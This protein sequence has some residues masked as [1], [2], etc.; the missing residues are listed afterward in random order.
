MIIFFTFLLRIKSGGIEK[1]HQ[2]CKEINREFK[3]KN[4]TK[5]FEK[6][7]VI[8]FGQRWKQ[9]FNVTGANVLWEEA[10]LTDCP[11]VQAYFPMS[12]VSRKLHY[13][14][15]TYSDYNINC[16]QVFLCTRGLEVPKN[17]KAKEVLS[18]ST[19][20]NY[21]NR[22]FYQVYFNISICQL[23]SITEPITITIYNEIEIP[24]TLHNVKLFGLI[25]QTFFFVICGVIA[26]IAVVA[27]TL[28]GTTRSTEIKAF[29]RQ[30]TYEHKGNRRVMLGKRSS[31]EPRT[32]LLDLHQHSTTLDS[33]E[34]HPDEG[35][36]DEGTSSMIFESLQY[37]RNPLLM[38]EM[39]RKRLIE[40]PKTRDKDDTALLTFKKRRISPPHHSV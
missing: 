37:R 11:V 3:N 21:A 5:R 38:T 35:T 30:N 8:P 7:A 24:Q 9:E 28:Y 19:K 18:L 15:N 12:S 29:S 13:T 31:E 16:A 2:N 1:S 26:G 39:E 22:E 27:G 10:M 20:R 40:A 17:I 6:Y 36:N 23:V 25:Q 4:C 34:E 33:I 32:E 14:A